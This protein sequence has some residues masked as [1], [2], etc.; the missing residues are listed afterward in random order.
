M[1]KKLKNTTKTAIG[2]EPVLATV[3]PKWDCDDCKHYPCAYNR[4]LKLK[5]KLNG[6]GDHS[7][8]GTP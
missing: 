1:S 3:L 5:I 8:R 2:Y 7:E 4:E 6:C